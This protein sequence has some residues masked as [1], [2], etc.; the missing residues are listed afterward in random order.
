VAGDD[1]TPA[2]YRLVLRHPDG[3]TE[4]GAIRRL[5]PDSPRIEHAFSTFEHGQPISWSIVDEEVEHDDAGSPYLALYAERDYGERDGALPDHQ[6]EHALARRGEELPEGAVAALDR[7]VGSGLAVELVALDPGEQPDWEEAERY[8]AALG[9]DEI[10]DDLFE[11]C[12]VD[13]RRDPQETWLDTVKERLTADLESF[14]D[15]VEGDHDEIEE[16][17]FRDG[18]I[19][20]SMGS[21]DDEASPVSGHGW[22]ARLCDA[23]VLGAAGFARVRRAELLP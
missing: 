1:A 4:R 20:V 18:R 12:G 13:T 21:P 10:G 19:F 5:R 7:A 16:W 17:D 14:R 9:F 11:R 15:D 6:L 2:R 23:G 3:R 22:L 8:I